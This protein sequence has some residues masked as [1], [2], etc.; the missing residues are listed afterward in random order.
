MNHPIVFA[1]AAAVAILCT[2]AAS[3]Q[4]SPSRYNVSS[5]S[6]PLKLAVQ[7]AQ[8]AVQTCGERGWPVTATVVDSAGLVIAQLRGD[9]AAV[10]TKDSAFRKA[11]TVITMGPVFGFDRTSEFIALA[12]KYP[13]GAQLATLPN[14]IAL[15]GAAAVK[16]GSEIVAGV[17]V[18]GSPGGDK[19]EACAEAGI[20][21]IADQVK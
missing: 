12:A 7:A 2:S 9:H 5:Y 11:Y 6:L 20:A 14:I 17:G 19:D 8:V 21:A 1:G 15:P 13:S 18:G 4:V 3:A 10:H 16:R